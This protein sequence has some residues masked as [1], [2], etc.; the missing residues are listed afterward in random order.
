MPVYLK[1]REGKLSLLDNYQEVLKHI[2]NPNSM[3]SLNSYCVV[4]ET[5][6]NLFNDKK[7]EEELIKLIKE[8]GKRKSG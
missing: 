4:S 8:Y 2:N 5:N 6:S 1:L 7:G 3:F